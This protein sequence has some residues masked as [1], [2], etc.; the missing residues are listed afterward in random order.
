MTADWTNLIRGLNSALRQLRAG[1]PE[2]M[3]G[4]SNIAQAALK[5]NAL[6]T[7]T[8]ELIALAIGVATRCDDCIAFH[9]KAAVQEGATWEEITETLG[10]AIYIWARH[11]PSCTR[12]TPWRPILNSRRLG[13]KRSTPSKPCCPVPPTRIKDSAYGGRR[14]CAAQGDRSSTEFAATNAMTAS[15]L[16]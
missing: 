1:A 12:P 3:K 11:H 6:D 7:K 15:P 5:A 4:F 10:L 13:L 9:A 14:N 16:Y 2:V 8:K